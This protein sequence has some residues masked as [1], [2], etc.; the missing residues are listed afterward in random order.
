VRK[1]AKHI[2]RNTK[3]Y[4]KKIPVDDIE[5]YLE[6]VRIQEITGGIRSAQ[7]DSVL[8]HIDTDRPLGSD[9]VTELPLT[10]PITRS[11][12]IRAP[13]DLN[14]LNNYKNLKPHSNVAPPS[15]DS[16]QPK[17][18]TSKKTKRLN[19]K[20]KQAHTKKLGTKKYQDSQKQRL[21]A[22]EKTTIDKVNTDSLDDPHSSIAYDLW[23]KKDEKK[24]KSQ[25]NC[26]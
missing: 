24:E 7:P 22:L 18:L 5:D 26:W 16:H 6:D 20:R 23:N 17:D 15:M 10:I 4:W 25:R 13:L 11:T 14:D 19:D 12:K 2:A 9:S 3:K 1:I 21:Q 8:Y